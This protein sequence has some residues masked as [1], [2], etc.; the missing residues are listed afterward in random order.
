M[1]GIGIEMSFRAI[2]ALQ[3]KNVVNH[4]LVSC[5]KNMPKTAYSSSIGSKNGIINKYLQY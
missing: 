1:V 3:L 2:K 4:I 5:S